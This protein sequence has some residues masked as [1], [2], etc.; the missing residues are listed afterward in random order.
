MRRTAPARPLAAV[1]AIFNPKGDDPA[2][3]V[4]L[5][6]LSYDQRQWAMPGGGIDPGESPA[7]AVVREVREET[8][9]DVEIEALYGVY[10]RRDND[11]I[12]FAFRCRVVGGT[13]AP[14]GGE[15]LELRYFPTDAL[16]R[17]I[18]NGTV[19]RIADARWNGPVLVRTL[20]R[21]EYQY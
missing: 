15:I 12:S 13:L 9:L 5:A 14:D 16:P 11:G 20:D 21:L 7:D 10:W 8:G 18:T 1:A 6:R 17:P 4:L 2:G 3:E 19:M